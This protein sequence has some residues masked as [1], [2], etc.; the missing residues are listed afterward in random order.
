MSLYWGHTLANPGYNGP[1]DEDG[2]VVSHV[3]MG[4]YPAD[5]YPGPTDGNV[6]RKSTNVSTVVHRIPPIV[7][8]SSGTLFDPESRFVGFDNYPQ[9]SHTIHPDSGSSDF[10]PVF[11]FYTGS[12]IVSTYLDYNQGAA[13]VTPKGTL[14]TGGV[15]DDDVFHFSFISPMLEQTEFKFEGATLEVHGTPLITFTG[16]SNPIALTAIEYARYINV[17]DIFM[18]MMIVERAFSGTGFTSSVV[19]KV[20]ERLLPLSHNYSN[21]DIADHWSGETDGHKFFGWHKLSMNLNDVLNNEMANNTNRFQIVINF[22][23]SFDKSATN[24]LQDSGYT[25]TNLPTNLKGFAMTE[26]RITKDVSTSVTFETGNSLV[27][28]TLEIGQLVNIGTAEEDG[29]NLRAYLGKKSSTAKYFK[30]ASSGTDI[31]IGSENRPTN[32]SNAAGDITI[33]DVSNIR[34]TDDDNTLGIYDWNITANTTDHVLRFRGPNDSTSPTV[35]Y[36]YLS[37]ATNDLS[38]YVDASVGATIVNLQQQD[39]DFRVAGDSEANLLF[40]DASTDRVGIITNTPS[41]KLDVTGGI[42]ATANITAYSDIRVKENIRPIENALLKVNQLEGVTY[43]RIDEDELEDINGRQIGLI[44][45][46]VEPIVPEVIEIDK[47][48]MYNL[49]YGNLAGL[50]VE[51]IKEQQVQIEELKREIE[52]LKNGSSK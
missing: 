1:K 29:F 33:K 6:W 47:E 48:G 5:M 2:S 36:D 9:T 51:A 27:S 18:E 28:D 14:G 43:D 44:A 15:V 32:S 16:V 7:G 10:S 11:A 52:E 13:S 45:Q 50:F 42:R 26:L 30:I 25:Y 23:Y 40:T 3:G 49:S 38:A 4:Y 12:G 31:T 17:G 34:F 19:K 24:S 39:I 8:G 21:A 35:R 41:Y 20:R 46:Q 22:T 37:F